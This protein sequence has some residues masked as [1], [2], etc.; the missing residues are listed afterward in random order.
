MASKLFISNLCHKN[1][2]IPIGHVCTKQLHEFS[3]V[4][5]ELQL[6]ALLSINRIPSVNKVGGRGGF[7]KAEGAFQ[8]G[9]S[10][11]LI[12]SGDLTSTAKL[13]E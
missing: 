4:V 6:A 5:T 2:H 13:L 9:R 7:F 8:A 1:I 3:P 12:F 11:N 10:Q